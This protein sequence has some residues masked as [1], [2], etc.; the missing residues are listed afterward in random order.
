ML[1]LCSHGFWDEG[2]C[3][4]GGPLIFYYVTLL[5]QPSPW[6][7]FKSAPTLKIVFLVL[8]S[9]TA[10]LSQMEIRWKMFQ[11]PC[12]F[13]RSVLY[14]ELVIQWD[15]SP[16]YTLPELSN[17]NFLRHFMCL[18]VTVS[19]IKLLISFGSSALHSEM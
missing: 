9:K 3:S 17:I 10:F 14:I 11:L 6:Q 13:C 19:S 18:F 7:I 12:Y 2:I 5:P 8:K 16:W 4:F 1:T 15:F